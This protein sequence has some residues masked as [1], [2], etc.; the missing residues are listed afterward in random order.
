MIYL[1]I[2]RSEWE[3]RQTACVRH[4]AELEVAEAV[5]QCHR[6]LD[7]R[8]GYDDAFVPRVVAW[9][10]EVLGGCWVE[11]L[12]LACY[13]ESLDI[14]EAVVGSVGVVEVNFHGVA[15]NLHLLEGHAF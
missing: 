4:V 7:F 6:L 10:P 12:V 13:L 1:P 11:Y 15:H 8:A 9:L 2:I 14:F 5:S 3:E